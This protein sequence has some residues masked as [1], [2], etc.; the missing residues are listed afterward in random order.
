MPTVIPEIKTIPSKKIIGMSI[1]TSR[2]NDTTPAMWRQ[3][4]PRR[5]EITNNLSDELISMQVF[6]PSIPFS[7]FNAH[8]QFTNWAAI[9]VA[10][11]DTVPHGMQAHTIHG[12]KYAVYLHKGDFKRYFETRQYIVGT[13]VPQNGYQL[14]D[15]EYFEILGER[16]KN[17]HPESEEEVWI[18]IK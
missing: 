1:S 13:W 14:D 15:R 6:D 5:K 4:M 16:Y 9:E 17:G 18:P 8:T 2:E 11:F 3:F 7:D 10:N 12:G